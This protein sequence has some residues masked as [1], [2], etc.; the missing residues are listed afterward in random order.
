[1]NFASAIKSGFNRYVD[2][3]GRSSR[4]EVWWW[5]LFSLIVN[6]IAAILDGA[7]GSGLFT[8]ITFFGMVIPSLAVQV[9]RMHD[10]D[11]SGWWL[12]ITLIPLI[13]AIIAL[14]WFC[15]KGTEGDNRFGSDPLNYFT[16]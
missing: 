10:L 16:T 6:V 3:T 7:G 9:R 8:I 14:V 12:L 4:S 5:I 1:M 11:K 13:G 2:F 15:S